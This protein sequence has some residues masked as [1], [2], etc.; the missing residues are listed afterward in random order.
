LQTTKLKNCS[1]VNVDFSWVKTLE[2]WKVTV[3]IGTIIFL[4][5]GFIPLVSTSLFD[6]TSYSNI[7]DVYNTVVQSGSFFSGSTATALIGL[8]LTAILYP[9]TVLLGLLSIAKRRLVIVAGILGILCWIGLL[10][11]L[12]ELQITQYTG[13]GVYL[14]F[15]GAIIILVSY[16]IKPRAMAPPAPPVAPPPPQ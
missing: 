12:N 15:I 9:L 5:S 16:F 13:L 3:L 1:D 2:N 11:A 7:F 14:G 10:I 6:F 4:I 8:W